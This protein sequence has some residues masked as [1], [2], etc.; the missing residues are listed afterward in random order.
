MRRMK[1]QK[2]TKICPRCRANEIFISE[3]AK[4]N[5]KIH[6]QEVC[7]DCYVKHLKGEIIERIINERE[8]NSA[9]VEH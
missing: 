8:E 5:P 7:E 3:W 2:H 9:T 6:G 4:H 1:K